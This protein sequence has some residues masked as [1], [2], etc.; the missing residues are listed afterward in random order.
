MMD[1]LY[2]SDYCANSKHD[3]CPETDADFGDECECVCHFAPPVVGNQTCKTCGS[4][5][6]VELIYQ[7]DDEVEKCAACVNGTNEILF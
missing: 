5:R 1:D 4:V 6:T 2:F 3:D 7:G